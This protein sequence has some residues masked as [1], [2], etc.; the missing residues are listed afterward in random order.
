MGYAREKFYNAIETLAGPSEQRKRLFDAFVFSLIH[1]NPERDLPE[2]MRQEFSDFCKQ[3]TRIPAQA[4]E[5]TAEATI[6]TMSDEEV[7]EA[8]SRIVGMNHDLLSDG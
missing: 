7:A 4:D 3:L 1:V 5:G 2:R 8:V 6:K